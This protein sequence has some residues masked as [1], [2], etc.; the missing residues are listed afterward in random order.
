LIYE[1]TTCW[2]DAG[3]TPK[4]EMGALAGYEFGGWGVFTLEKKAAAS[5][6]PEGS[7]VKKEQ[8]KEI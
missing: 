4:A 2:S 8:V 5:E 3:L 7:H 1:R 6:P